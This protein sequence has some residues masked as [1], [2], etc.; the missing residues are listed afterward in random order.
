MTTVWA[1]ES[2]ILRSGL[3]AQAQEGGMAGL[4]Q[5]GG[6]RVAKG[7]ARSDPGWLNSAR[8]AE[9]DR[10]ESLKLRSVRC[11]GL[12]RQLARWL[13]QCGRETFRSRHQSIEHVP[14]CLRQDQ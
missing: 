11:C 5:T 12:H 13:R 4:E 10:S 2:L 1:P 9:T 8:A 6:S 3:T 14:S 7:L